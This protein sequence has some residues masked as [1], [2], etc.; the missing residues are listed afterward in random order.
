MNPYSGV[1]RE[2]ARAPAEY[3]MPELSTKLGKLARAEEVRAEELR[4]I[5]DA[6]KLNRSMCHKF[7]VW[8]LDNVWR[9]LLVDEGKEIPEK[10]QL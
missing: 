1:L 9:Q 3:C 10:E 7:V 8:V 6:C 4:E 5:L 2:L